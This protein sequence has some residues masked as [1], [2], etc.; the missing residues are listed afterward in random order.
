MIDSIIDKTHKIVKDA[1]EMGMSHITIEGGQFSGMEKVLDK[2]ECFCNFSICDY[3]KLSTDENVKRAAVD[4]V[5]NNGVYAAVSRTY[6][7]LNIYKEA[8]EA[9]SEIFNKPVIITPRTTLAHISAIPILVDRKDAV[10][11]DHQVHTSVRLATDMIKS[12]GIHVET[13]RHNRLDKL[14]ERIIELK[15]KY[16]YVWYMAD[17]L[18]SMYGDVIPIKEIEALMNKYEQF[19]L[20]VDDAHA[21]GWLGE[22][23]EGYVLSQI[24]YHPQMILV[25]SLGKGFGSGGGAIV[26]PDENIRERILF[27]G[28][29]LMFTS[30]PEPSTLGAIIE[31]SKIHL[32]DEIKGKRKKL[33]EQIEYFYTYAESLGLPVVDNTRTPIAF[34]AAGNPEMVTKVCRK[35]LDYG[36]HITPGVYPATPFNNGGARVVL[37]L[38]Q[39]KEDIKNMLTLLKEVH[40]K[41]LEE[42]GMSIDKILSYYKK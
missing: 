34:V 19:R 32:G 31:A 15:D 8:E 21:A 10:I 40:T 16:R 25:T 27:C 37:S 6:M 24:D 29:T 36:Y 41:V 18:Y 42:Y 12:Y 23:G 7:K 28:T 11:L 5:M 20:Y 30:P 38:Y 9:V 17:G 3:L 2:N 13:V 26:C 22:N 35:M 1:C 33:S 14:E 4:A 39:T